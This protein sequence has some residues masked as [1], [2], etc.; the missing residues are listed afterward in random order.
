VTTVRQ[1]ERSQTVWTVVDC[2]RLMRARMDGRSKL[3]YATEAAMRLAQLANYGGDSSA[4]LAYGTQIQ[5]RRLAGNGN[6]HLHAML[7]QPFTVG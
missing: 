2:G 3:D 4:M 6:L 7:D 1:S 5:Q